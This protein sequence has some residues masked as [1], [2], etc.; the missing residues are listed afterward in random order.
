MALPTPV[1]RIIPSG[2][3]MHDGF[4]TQIAFSLNPAFV[5]WER[6]VKPPGVSTGGNKLNTTTMLNEERRTF[7]PPT[8]K[9]NTD[10]S[11]TALFDP[12]AVDDADFLVGKNQP[13]SWHYPNNAV[14]TAWAYL[15]EFTPNDF[16]PDEVP[17]AGFVIIV[18]NWDSVLCVESDPVFTPGVGTCGYTGL[19]V[20]P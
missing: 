7:A 4:K 13:I 11:G 20:S 8:L 19:L 10:G 15:Q 3:K 6:T 17:T 5:M 9:E 12:T 1:V 2:F 16:N 14:W 18:T